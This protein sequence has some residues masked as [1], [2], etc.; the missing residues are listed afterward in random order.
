METD[1]LRLNGL[2]SGT[3]RQMTPIWHH[4]HAARNDGGRE[5][6]NEAEGSL[7]YLRKQN[8]QSGAT[9][10]IYRRQVSLVADLGEPNQISDEYCEEQAGCGVSEFFPAPIRKER[11]R[12]QED[13]A[14]KNQN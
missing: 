6:K 5:K 1:W 4:Q 2:P 3:P 12:R 10:Y 8:Q 13:S 7:R 14:A 11:Q 9:Q